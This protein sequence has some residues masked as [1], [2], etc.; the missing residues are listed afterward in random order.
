MAQPF[1][2]AANCLLLQA[3]KW[4]D[5]AAA[6]ATSSSLLDTLLQQL[7][8]SS[9]LQHLA[10]VMAATAQQIWELQGQA[11]AQALAA[12]L[13]DVAYKHKQDWLP[14]NSKLQR[15]HLVAG[16]L[17]GA[18]GNLQEVAVSR[19]NWHVLVQ[20]VAVPALE[21]SVLTMQHVSTCLEV[22][23]A[24]LS[25]PPQSLWRAVGCQRMHKRLHGVVQ[26]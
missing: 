20:V 3:A 13:A 6:K 1:A 21:L 5:E 2:L 26:Q 24:Q 7:Q 23:P 19:C 8:Q 12:D 10:A 18:A 16:Q 11:R 17:C 25:G 15:L 9:L 22:L 14:S 4:G